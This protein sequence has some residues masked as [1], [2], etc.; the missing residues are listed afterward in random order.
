MFF[1][2][3]SQSEHP[4]KDFLDLPLKSTLIFIFFFTFKHSE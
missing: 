4:I 1:E 3:M 2:C